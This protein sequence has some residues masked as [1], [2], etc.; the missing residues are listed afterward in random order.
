MCLSSAF[1]GFP[2]GVYSFIRGLRWVRQHPLILVLL[3]VPAL[4]GLGLI[5]LT[6]GGFLEY[7]G[8]IFEGIMF[9]RPESW[10]GLG[11][12]HLVRGLLYLAVFILGFIFYVLIV[13]VVSS[14]I[15]D[16]VSLKVERSVI[17]GPAVAISFGESLKL[18]G[19]EL[20]KVVFIMLISLGALLIPG[21]NILAPF[22]TA[23]CLG[24]ELYDFPLARRGWSFRKRLSFVYHHGW[25][26]TGLGIWLLIPGV[27]FILMPL[28]VVGATMMA[29]EDV[30]Q[31][32]QRAESDKNYT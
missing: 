18:M 32:M 8:V 28:A 3:L 14:P 13:S 17:G 26:V 22:V 24:W 31:Q 6:W 10:W 23:F 15:Y 30:Q 19:E 27:Q 12:Y 20:K 5:F 11:L 2:R 7:Q 16:Y 29:A 1:R 9:S 25:S 21:I 4:T